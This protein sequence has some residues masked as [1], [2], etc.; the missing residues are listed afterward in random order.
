MAP[1]PFGSE[2][3]GVWSRKPESAGA[4][5]VELDEARG[6]VADGSARDPIA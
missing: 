3:V 2:T 5:D 6:W 1:P 4:V